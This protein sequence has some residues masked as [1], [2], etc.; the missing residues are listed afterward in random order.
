[1]R[2]PAI[3][4]LTP[5]DWARSYLGYP[6]VQHAQPNKTHFALSALS[7]AG[8]TRELITQNVDRLHHKAALDEEAAE[9]DILELHG[10]LN[11]VICFSCSATFPRSPFQT[12]LSELNPAWA[13]YA[14]KLERRQIEPK[15]NPDGDVD[16][17]GRSYDD[18][19]VP[20]C[21]KCG[22]NSIRTS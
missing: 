19:N 7:A 8:W 4:L 13:E 22:E 10:A 9:K 14:E 17:G 16:L 5:A 15:L 20:R 2:L 18:F 21:Y 11:K 1:M 12:H 6:P 3:R